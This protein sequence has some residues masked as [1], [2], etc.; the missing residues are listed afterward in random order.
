MKAT[1]IILLSLVLFINTAYSQIEYKQTIR[2]RVID[3]VTR[4]PLPGANVIILNTN[5]LIAT[6][7]D[8]DGKFRFEEIPIGRQSIQV[9]YVGYKSAAVPNIIVNSAKE[10]VL[11]VEM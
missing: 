9:T 5:P 4:T 6:I 1:T 8:P 7:T 10:I 2:G 11:E 3:K